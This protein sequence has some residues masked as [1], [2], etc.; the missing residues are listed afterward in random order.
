[1]SRWFYDN[2]YAE[3]Y[4]NSLRLKGSPTYKHHIETYGANFDYYDFAPMFDRQVQKWNPAEW[5]RLSAKPVRAMPSSPRSTTTA[6]ACGPAA[7]S[8]QIAPVRKLPP[9]A[10]WWAIWPERFAPRA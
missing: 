10:I 8:I 4:L 1:M 9:R 5:A 2:A 7:F 6:S 3:W